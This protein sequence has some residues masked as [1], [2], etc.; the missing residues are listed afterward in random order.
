MS[1]M[2][3]AYRQKGKKGF[4]LIE[5]IVVIVIIAI[6][7]AAL[8]PA[9]LGVIESAN[10][11]GDESDARS[12][13]MAASVA[14]LALLDPEGELEASMIDDEL[15]GGNIHPGV[16]VTLWFSGPMCVAAVIDEDGWGRATRT[17]DIV[18][19]GNQDV[20]ESTDGLWEFGPYSF[21]GN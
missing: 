7:I 6:L 1:K 15:I 9:I 14:A 20:L 17:T 12:M 8:T 16:E 10:R 19:V 2:L 4:T 18:A 3:K 21:T 11:S 5:L 13:M